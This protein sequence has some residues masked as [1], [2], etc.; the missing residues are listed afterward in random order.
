MIDKKPASY[1][2][3]HKQRPRSVE[4]FPGFRPSNTNFSKIALRFRADSYYWDTPTGRR[5]LHSFA[6][7]V[8]I[9]NFTA[10]DSGVYTLVADKAADSFPTTQ[11]EVHHYSND[12]TSPSVRS[13]DPEAGLDHC[14]ASAAPPPLPVCDDEDNSSP[15][16][17]DHYEDI[18]L[19][20]IAPGQ[21]ASQTSTE[22]TK[23]DE[24]EMPYGIAASNSVYEDANTYHR[25]S[26]DNNTQTSQYCAVDANQIETNCSL[27]R[28]SLYGHHSENI[29]VARYCSNATEGL[30]T[31]YGSCPSTDE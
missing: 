3:P 23:S 1:G 31:L 18:D 2:L 25:T 28:N 30:G 17:A 20:E 15:Q 5:H 27:S 22:E 9:T 4:R 16:A 8:M 19:P 21:P 26:S 11:A 10:K 12:V 13:G 6:D 7:P 24:E 14:Y 29:A